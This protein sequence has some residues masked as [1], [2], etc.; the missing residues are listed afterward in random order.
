[1]IGQR[2]GLAGQPEIVFLP[3]I[4][5]KSDR[6]LGSRIVTGCFLR[7]RRF[8][9]ENSNRCANQTDA[10]HDAACPAHRTLLPLA[11]PPLMRLP[12]NDRPMASKR[13]LFCAT[14]SAL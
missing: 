10:D 8:K 3:S 1:V 2:F 4:E 14:G 13:F 12:A 5:P 9:G 11:L 7:T 6:L